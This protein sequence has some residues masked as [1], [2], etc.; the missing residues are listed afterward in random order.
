LCNELGVSNH[1]K[2]ENEWVKSVRSGNAVDWKP[3][4]MGRNL[5][6]DVEGMTFRDAVYLLEQSGLHV[7]HEGKGRVQEQS[8]PPGRRIH[9]GD[10]IYIRL[11]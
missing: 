1:S 9:K 3:A 4:T 2:T 6:P 5:V 8:L 10:R 11:S 7:V